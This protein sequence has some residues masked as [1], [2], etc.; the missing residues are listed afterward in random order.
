M[1]KLV[2]QNLILEACT[3]MQVMAEEI[4]RAVKEDMESE[5]DDRTNVEEGE[6]CDDV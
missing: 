3:C 5:A 4:S 6:D 1:D 2:I